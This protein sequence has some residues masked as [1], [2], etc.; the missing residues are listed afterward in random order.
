MVNF[1]KKLNKGS[2][3][4]WGTGGIL[5]QNRIT[6]L[7]GMDLRYIIKLSYNEYSVYLKE[8]QH[9]FPHQNISL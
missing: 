6:E 7:L 4:K 9:F 8:R 5:E 1:I 2:A 3:R